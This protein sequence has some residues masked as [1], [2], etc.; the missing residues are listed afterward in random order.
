ME[1]CHHEP[2]SGQLQLTAV[3]LSL[4]KQLV[5]KRP[6][7]PQFCCLR[8]TQRKVKMYFLQNQAAEIHQKEVEMR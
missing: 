8:V 6:N 4:M 2:I 1:G 5:I 7:P 3:H